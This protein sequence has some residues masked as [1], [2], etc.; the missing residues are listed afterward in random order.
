[1]IY[2]KR[3]N[4][5]LDKYIE[6]KNEKKCKKLETHVLKNTT[7]SNISENTISY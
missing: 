4:E 5:K 2:L 6:D 1:M 7:S 3:A